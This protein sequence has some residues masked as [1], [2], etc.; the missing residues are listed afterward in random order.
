MGRCP[1]I[2]ASRIT[3]SE[4]EELVFR[5]DGNDK[6]LYGIS[7]GRTNVERDRSRFHD[8]SE[9]STDITYIH[10]IC[11]FYSLQM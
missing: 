5:M 11:S 7:L 2:A 9:Y 3:A 4:D 1:Y 10:V 6:E 8:I